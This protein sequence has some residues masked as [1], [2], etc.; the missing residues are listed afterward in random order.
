MNTDRISTAAALLAEAS[1]QLDHEY[2]RPLNAST[3]VG[4]L[5]AALEASSFAPNATLAITVAPDDHSGALTTRAH[6]ELLNAFKQV[7]STELLT[8]TARVGV[9]CREL[10][11]HE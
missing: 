3:R 10:A 7:P 8:L 4:L 2:T 9:L 6:D 1:K 5:N 11:R